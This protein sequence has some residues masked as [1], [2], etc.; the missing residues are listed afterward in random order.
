MDDVT[1]SPVPRRALFLNRRRM[2]TKYTFFGPNIL[3]SRR[4]MC[5]R[6]SA[7]MAAI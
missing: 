3:C 4:S 2:P 6:Y 1:K 5:E 7:G